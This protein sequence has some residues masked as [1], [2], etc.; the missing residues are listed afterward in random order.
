MGDEYAWGEKRISRERRVQSSASTATGFSIIR[1][2]SRFSGSQVRWRILKSWEYCWLTSTLSHIFHLAFAGSDL[3]PCQWT[4][5]TCSREYLLWRTESPC[6]L[7]V[8][9]SKQEAGQSVLSLCSR[10][11]LK[12]PTVVLW[13]SAINCQH[14]T[15]KV[16]S[17]QVIP[18]IG[19]QWA[20][21][22]QWERRIGELW[23]QYK[24]I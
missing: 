2:S 13:K 19:A 7:S 6:I 4:S 17:V 9:N 18:P 12:F 24:L 11:S 3:S 22:D 16:R 10:S 23:P 20:A 14:A 8:V 1:Y 15:G 21:G 5:L